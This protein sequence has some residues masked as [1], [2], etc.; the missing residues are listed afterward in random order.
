MTGRKAGILT[1]LIFHVACMVAYYAYVPTCVISVWELVKLDGLC[2]LCYFCGFG[3]SY[4]N[5]EQ[6]F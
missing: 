3:L 1:L 6:G 2:A 5:K 4:F